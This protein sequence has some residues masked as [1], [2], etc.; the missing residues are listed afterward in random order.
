[1]SGGITVSLVD[2][3]MLLFDSVRIRCASIKLILMRNWCGP[4][5]DIEIP[6]AHILADRVGNRQ[7]EDFGLHEARNVV[8]PCAVVGSR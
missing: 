4:R 6:A 1:M 7:P 3:A 2:F 8:A 5:L